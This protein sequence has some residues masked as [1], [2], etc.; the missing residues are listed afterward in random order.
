MRPCCYLFA[1]ILMLLSST[2]LAESLSAREII[3]RVDQLLRGDSSLAT[4]QMSVATEHW[5][6]TME[7]RIWS[8][9]TEK[10]LIKVLEPKKDAGTATLRVGDNIWNYLPKIDRVI[11]VPTSMMMASWMGSHFTNDDLVKES[12]LVRDYDISMAYEGDRDGVTVYEFSLK[13]RPEAAVVW[14]EITYQVRKAD[15]MPVWARYY[16]EDGQLKRV[17]TFGDYRVLGGRRV[18][19]T[20]RVVPQD[21]PGEYTEILYKDLQFNPHLSEDVF[22]LRAL[23][24]GGL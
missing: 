12:R 9:G 4:V 11:R 2:G 1:S 16:G 23:R 19:A 13:P 5:K 24:G 8:E 17:M 14:G 21:K 10:V 18:P 3:D 6:R 20:M 7:L 22:S 15:L